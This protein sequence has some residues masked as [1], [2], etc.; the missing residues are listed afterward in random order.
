MDLETT[1]D[2]MED[3]FEDSVK[4]LTDKTEDNKKRFQTLQGRLSKLE[5]RINTN[6]KDFKVLQIKA[7]IVEN[8]M[9][10]YEDRYENQKKVTVI[11]QVFKRNSHMIRPLLHS[12]KNFIDHFVREANSFAAGKKTATK[13][14]KK[15]DKV[16]QTRI[17]EQDE[18]CKES[19]NFET[20]GDV[21]DSLAPG[22]VTHNLIINLCEK[23][24]L[25]MKLLFYVRE[26]ETSFCSQFLND[27]KYNNFGIK[28]LIEQRANFID[29]EHMVNV[30]HTL[31]FCINF[32]KKCFPNAKKHRRS[33]IPKFITPVKKQP[34][35]SLK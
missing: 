10:K 31:L 19:K 12:V 26:I 15:D 24:K 6:D 30:Y 32:F 34:N 7:S 22:N 11:Q 13:D 18:A 33:K 23:F 16:L 8:L 27:R 17:K 20:I 5:K 9:K 4:C 29:D 28:E 14:E 21:M 2:T 3:K 35:K 25:D 1:S